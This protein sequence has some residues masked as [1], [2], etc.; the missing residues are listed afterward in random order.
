MPRSAPFRVFLPRASVYYGLLYSGVSLTLSLTAVGAFASTAAPPG[1]IH[2]PPGS[3]RPAPSHDRSPPGRESPDRGSS[4]GRDK[5]K[6]PD[7]HH[8]GYSESPH[9]P[10][11]PKGRRRQSSG[12]RARSGPPH[13]PPADHSEPELERII[14]PELVSGA[15]PPER[16]TAP[17]PMHGGDIDHDLIDPTLGPSLVIQPTGSS[18][19]RMSLAIAAAQEDRRMALLPAGSEFAVDGPSGISIKVQVSARESRPTDIS[20]TRGLAL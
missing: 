2:K 3:H 9:T 1:A 18:S 5:D 11:R 15:P 13:G 7:E 19:S 8:S 17:A 12:R 16:H 10:E 4:H 14:Q 20:L 6:G